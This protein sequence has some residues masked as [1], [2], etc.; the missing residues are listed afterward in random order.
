MHTMVWPTTL[1]LIKIMVGKHKNLANVLHYLWT[2]HKKPKKKKK[3]SFDRLARSEVKWFTFH[4][5]FKPGNQNSIER[6]IAFIWS[7]HQVTILECMPN[8]LKELQ[9]L[10]QNIKAFGQVLSRS[11]VQPIIHGFFNTKLLN[12]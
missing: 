3:T 4:G 7:Q 2:L 11:I 10:L 5:R 8:F 1:A 6:D 12:C 9:F